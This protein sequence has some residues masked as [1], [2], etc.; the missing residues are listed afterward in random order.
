MK[1][2]LGFKFITQSSILLQFDR[3]AEK[4]CVT[5]NGITR[6]LAENWSK[7]RPNESA[8][9]WYTRVQIV[10]MFSSFLRDLGF[11]SYVLKLPPYPAYNFIPYIY[12]PI[13]IKAIFKAADGLVL[14]ERAMQSSIFSVPALLRLLYATGVRIGEALSLCETDVNLGEK[15]FKIKD[16]K[17]G[18]ERI[19]PISSSLANVLEQYLLHKR[20]LPVA[21]MSNYFF[22]RLDGKRCSHQSVAQWFRRCLNEADVRCIKRNN[23]PRIHDLRHTFAVTSLAAMAE[24]GVD[25]YAS[26]P[27][28]STYLGHQSLASTNH[29][30]RLTANMYP[31][32]IRDMD[33]LCL[34][35]FPKLENY[36]T[37]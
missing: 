15:Y 36:E 20:R 9:F 7:R 21:A 19:V 28:L 31:D 3:L 2:K 16:S 34:D 33:V 27:I 25:L 23:F 32:L 18:K 30:V 26:L 12:S 14:R 11:R 1:R 13:E 5:A 22:V 29:Y 6:P 37:N 24:D 35:V 17:N 8:S 10:S 4:E